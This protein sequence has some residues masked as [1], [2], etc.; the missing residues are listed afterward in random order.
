MA[1]IYIDRINNLDTRV[2]VLEILQKDT[3]KSIDHHEILID[4]LSG[5]NNE[6]TLALHDISAKFDRLIAQISTGSKIVA[7]TFVLITTLVAA[8]WTYQTHIETR[9][10][11][12]TSVSQQR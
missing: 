2:I 1:D 10:S 5:Q 9:I 6:M 12:A 4:K 7:A 11:Q 3:S 8:A